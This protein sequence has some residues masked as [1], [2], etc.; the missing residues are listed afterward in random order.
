MKRRLALL[1]SSSILKKSEYED[2]REKGSYYSTWES[3]QSL[4]ND[5]WQYIITFISVTPDSLHTLLKILLTCK[6]AAMIWVFPVIMNLSVFLLKDC[7]IVNFQKCSKSDQFAISL[8][9]DSLLDFTCFENFGYILKKWLLKLKIDNF[10]HCVMLKEM[11]TF[12]NLFTILSIL[13]LAHLENEYIYKKP[14]DVKG[15]QLFSNTAIKTIKE[16]FYLYKYAFKECSPTTLFKDI[17]HYDRIKDEYKPLLKLSNIKTLVMDGPHKVRRDSTLYN[18]ALK[19]A[20][21]HLG[22][23]T[24]YELYSLAMANVTQ[25]KL[26]ALIYYGMEEEL[27]VKTPK[28][29]DKYRDLIIFDENDKNVSYHVFSVEAKDFHKNCLCYS[30]GNIGKKDD[31]KSIIKKGVQ[32]YMSRK[33]YD[34]TF[35]ISFIRSFILSI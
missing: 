13:H 26:R 1:A 19:I 32:F 6:S 23:T 22:D 9:Q 24:E 17:I 12:D 33:K 27:E 18:E 8:P 35:I 3:G 28:K 20:H 31:S 16:R 7:F 30:Q 25:D 14:Y 2:V 15:I 10:E 21:K 34:Y 5:I 29:N 11:Q 4:P